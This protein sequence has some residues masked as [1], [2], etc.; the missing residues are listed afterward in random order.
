MKTASH[1]LEHEF[2]YFVTHQ[3]ELVAKYNGKFIVIIGDKVVG[4]F[5]T[6][7]GALEDSQKKYKAG[8]YLIQHC[9]PGKES[10]TQT[11]HSRVVFS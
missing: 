6:F 9:R 1:L 8:T 10:Y 4:S 3:D 2:K 5:D 7:E 11:F